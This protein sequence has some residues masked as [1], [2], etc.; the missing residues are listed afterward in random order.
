MNLVVKPTA[1]GTALVL[2]TDYVATFAT[3]AL[4]NAGTY[5]VAVTGVGAWIDTTNVTFTVAR[6]PVT[7]TAEDKSK[8]AGNADPELTATYEGV[9]A[10]EEFVPA[11][12][13]ARA[14]G[15]DEL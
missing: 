8:V 1:A 11:Y 9:V 13:L 15:E 12:T 14:Q 3:N 5:T 4:V 6:A 2:D 7:V 10:G